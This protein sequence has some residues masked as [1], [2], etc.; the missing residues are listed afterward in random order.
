MFD[1][2]KNHYHTLGVDRAATGDQIKTAFREK[3]KRYHP[4]VCK[5]PGAED[6]FKDV[7]A[8]Y[9]I[10]SDPDKRKEYDTLLDMASGK[11]IDIETIVRDFAV[12]QQHTHQRR[13]RRRR[14]RPQ[15]PGNAEVEEIPDG[16]LRDNRNRDPFFDDS[17]G[18]IL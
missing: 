7:N 10:L 12:Q 5:E 14:P 6:L 13:Q 1:L 9:E 2:S 17:L 15:H 3:A 18:G 16:F 11:R 8:A 4:D